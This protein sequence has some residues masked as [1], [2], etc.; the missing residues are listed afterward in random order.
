MSLLV[1]KEEWQSALEGCPPI[2]QEMLIALVA[3]HLEA[4]TTVPEQA[5]QQWLKEPPLDRSPRNG[6][7]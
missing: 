2:A 5:I 6:L 7:F 3:A 4:H 1:W